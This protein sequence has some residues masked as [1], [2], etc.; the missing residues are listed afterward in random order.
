[1]EITKVEEARLTYHRCNYCGEESLVAVRVLDAEY[2]PRHS[3]DGSFERWPHPLDEGKHACPHCV[4]SGAYLEGKSGAIVGQFRIRGREEKIADRWWY[5]LL[6]HPTA[7]G[8]ALFLWP[9]DG[10]WYIPITSGY[11]FSTTSD[12]IRGEHV[13]LMA[14][15]IGLI[16]A[17]CDRDEDGEVVRVDPSQY[18]AVAAERASPDRLCIEV[19]WRRL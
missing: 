13:K 8:K 16:D 17:W 6:P 14:E 18:G 11:S 1:M 9:S 19:N 5:A 12:L 2:G 15:G 7:E 3:V 4:K 10:Q